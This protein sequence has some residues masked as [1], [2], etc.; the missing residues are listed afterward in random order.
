MTW[1]VFSSETEKPICDIP[2]KLAINP[3][4]CETG[5]YLSH[6]LSYS[7]N[8]TQLSLSS[9]NRLWAK[10][11]PHEVFGAYI[12]RYGHSVKRINRTLT[13][14]CH[15]HRPHSASPMVWFW[16]CIRTFSIRGIASV[17]TTWVF[18]GCSVS[19]IDTAAIRPADI[20]ML[21]KAARL[22]ITYHRLGS[23]CWS[24]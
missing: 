5:H 17:Y 1:L 16:T 4:L 2:M 24:C 21:L 11:I 8:R 12:M 23:L 20:E 22:F 10:K 14:Y 6:D 13:I 15:V 9:E 19:G 3:S 7:C 18:A